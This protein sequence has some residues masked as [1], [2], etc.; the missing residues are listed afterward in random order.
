[1][2]IFTYNGGSSAGVVL[3]INACLYWSHSMAQKRYSLSEVGIRKVEAV[4][5]TSFPPYPSTLF[6][7]YRRTPSKLHLCEWGGGGSVEGCDGLRPGGFL[8]CPHL[9]IV[10]VPNAF[11]GEG[12]PESCGG[13]ELWHV[14]FGRQ[15]LPPSSSH[16]HRQEVLGLW[17]DQNSTVAKWA[18]RA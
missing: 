15:S 1:D 11:G 17:R 9:V 18:R 5:A 6:T 7:L 8:F 14:G 4:G 3:H 16:G 13:A 2:W 10:L 12:L